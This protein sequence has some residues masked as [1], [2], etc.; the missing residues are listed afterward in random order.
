MDWE[1]RSKIA[2]T[3][4][5]KTISNK[6]NFCS[7]TVFSPYFESGA[8]KIHAAKPIDYPL[9]FLLRR[10]QN[11]FSDLTSKI[12]KMREQISKT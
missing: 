4:Q 2:A 8:K 5:K 11:K 7:N 6:T 12:M 1:N 9:H 3:A 10:Y